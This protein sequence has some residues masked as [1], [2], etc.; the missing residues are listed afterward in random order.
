MFC[1]SG[2][3][4]VDK[5]VSYN[6]D[7]K[8]KY[9]KQARDNVTAYLQEKYPDETFEILNIMIRKSG[10]NGIFESILPSGYSKIAYV[11]IVSE[12]GEWHNVT[13]N[14]KESGESGKLSCKDDFQEKVVKEDIENAIKKLVNINYENILDC[15]ISFSEFM[16]HAKYDG[17]ISFFLREIKTEDENVDIYGSFVY[18]GELINFSSFTDAEKYFL[19]YIDTVL[20]VAMKENTSFPVNINESIRLGSSFKFLYP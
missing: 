16:F 5:I 14:T 4:V 1:F 18:D 19:Y 12:S 20:F 17:D 13:T 15:K 10:H 6:E 2:C 7:I 11:K 3:E 9:E 8:A